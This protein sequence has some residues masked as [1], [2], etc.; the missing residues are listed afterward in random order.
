VARFREHLID[1]RRVQAYADAEL[2]L[3]TRQVWGEFSLM[4]WAFHVADPQLPPAFG[5]LPPEHP[6]RCQGALLEKEAEVSRRL[7]RFQHEQRLRFQPERRSDPRFQRD[8]EIALSSPAPV[9]GTDV[10]LSTNE[11]LI[12]C[13]CE[14]AGMLGAIRWLIDDRRVWGEAG[15][16]D[17]PDVRK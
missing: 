1:R 10:R 17:L 14:H 11:A 3:R 13:A 6:F 7:W 8:H 15:I 5:S 12:E 2:V 9:Y 16:M 4:C